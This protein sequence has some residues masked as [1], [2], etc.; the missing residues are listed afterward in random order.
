MNHM[1]SIARSA[2][3]VCERFTAQFRHTSRELASIQQISSYAHLWISRVQ[4]F[5]S[6]LRHSQVIHMLDMGGMLSCK[7]PSGAHSEPLRR[8][9]RWVAIALVGALCLP[10]SEA[11]SGSQVHIQSIRLLADYQ[12][13][14]KQEYCHNQIVYRESRFNRL[15]VNGSHYGYYQGHSKV[16]YN[17]PTDY[18]FYW[19]WAYVSDRYGVTRYDEPNYCKALHHLRVKGWQ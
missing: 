14:E 7:S 18:Q 11:S 1:T 3:R 12:L 16:L 8:R 2:G 13:T 5:T 17:A 15:A 6:R 10:M 9:V 19:Y 4:N